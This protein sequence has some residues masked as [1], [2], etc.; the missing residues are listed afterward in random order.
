VFCSEVMIRYRSWVSCSEFVIGYRNW[1]FCSEL[2]FVAELCVPQRNCDSLPKLC[3]LQ[4]ISIRCRSW[5]VCSEFVI[6]CRNWVPAANV[7]SL[8]NHVFCSE[9]VIRCRSWVVCSEFVIGCQNCVICSELAFAAEVELSAVNLWFANS[10][11]KLSCLQRICDSLPQLSSYS[12]LAFA[13]ESCV[14]ERCCDSL[15]KLSCLQRI[16]DSLSKL[17]CPHRISIHCWIMC[18]TAKLWFTAETVSSAAN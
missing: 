1:V 3:R 7:N 15:P 16:C 12:E 13:A 8:L 11:L 17:S 9:V 4:R 6:R 14:L 10:L 18:S 5:V 2:T